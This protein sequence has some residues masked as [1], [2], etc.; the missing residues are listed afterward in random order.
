MR[1]AIYARI[2][3]DRHD[4]AGVDRQLQDCRALVKSN[5]WGPAVE[6]VD[7]SVSAYSGKPRPRYL[8]M[9]AA[10]RDGSLGRVVV[11]H[12]DRLYRQPRELEDIID[13]ALSLRATAMQRKLVGAT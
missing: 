11:W 12:L 3:D 7:N 2:S 13:L 1:T 6:F 5:G 9:L 4:G 10:L 8:A